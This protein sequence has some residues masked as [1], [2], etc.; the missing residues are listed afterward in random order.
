MNAAS[1]RILSIKIP[2]M[3]LSIQTNVRHYDD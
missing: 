1:F 3:M 2:D